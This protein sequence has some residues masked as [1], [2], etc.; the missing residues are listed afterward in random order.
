MCVN[1]ILR[2]D[3]EGGHKNAVSSCWL[4]MSTAFCKGAPGALFASGR[5][6][7]R[8]LAMSIVPEAVDDLD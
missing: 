4:E 7:G 2:R 8:V 3:W 5:P 6:F 1:A